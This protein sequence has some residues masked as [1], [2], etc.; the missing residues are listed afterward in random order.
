MNPQEKAQHLITLFLGDVN[1][2]H[3]HS[4]LVE[5]ELR[6]AKAYDNANYFSKVTKELDHELIKIAC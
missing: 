5:R 4:V 6:K 3:T 1:A 2:A